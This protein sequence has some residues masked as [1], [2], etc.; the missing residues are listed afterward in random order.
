M[1]FDRI[2]G[3]LLREMILNGAALLESNKADINQLN[4]FPVPDGDTGTNMSLTLQNACR[5]V[6]AVTMPTCPAVADAL[7]KGALKGARGN[8]GVIL[9]QLFRG[10]SKG[11]DGNQELD[12][13][14]F[15]EA[16]RAGVETA[17]KAVMKPREGTILTVSRACAEEAARQA[18]AGADV[19]TLMEAVLE[20]GEQTLQRTPDMLDVLKKAGV[21]DAGGRG[22]L[23][24]YEGFLASLQG[25][26]LVTPAPKAAQPAVPAAPSPKAELFEPFHDEDVIE[27]GYCTEFL[28]ENLKPNVDAA[29]IERLRARLETLGDS[30]VLVHD[31]TILKVHIHS[32]T[33]DKVLTLA[34]QLG[35]LSA[36]KIE[37]MREQH[38]EIMERRAA[39]APQPSAPPKEQAIVAVAAGE[40][41]KGI[42]HDIMVDGFV[43]GG[44]T[45]NPSAEDI[46]TAIRAVNANHVLVLPNNSNI[47]LA[48]R[49]AVEL[50]GCQV[51]VVPTKTVPQGI[52]AAL[53]FNPE[54]SP[55]ENAQAM[56]DAFKI[57]RSGSV[58]YAVRDSSADGF[59]I[60]KGDIL[61]IGEKAIVAVG[62]SVEEV[63]ID[64]VRS[65]SDDQSSMV[66]FYWGADVREQ[67]ALAL[68][69]RIRAEFKNCDAEAYH[70]GQPIYYY[71]VSVE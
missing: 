21:V 52:A 62:Q 1:A 56:A 16:M 14:T 63:T 57:V 58:T 42:F 25:R 68:R 3:A 23:T 2:D 7:A 20:Y 67:D 27:K 60:K 65:L 29:A 51:Y 64:L 32:E 54:A 48:A 11:V 37:N 13:R 38:R 10:F 12:A 66:S 24:I 69:D 61:G 18:A 53:A 31:E 22:L 46:A 55:E 9:S 41:I 44:Q 34:L 49:Q 59:D 19:T 30:M 36:I 8:S 47:I 35:E 43:E 6:Q 71:I 28:I 45:M 5:E 50:V 39:S 70:G 15:A 33:P 4:V 40:G 17:Y 26:G